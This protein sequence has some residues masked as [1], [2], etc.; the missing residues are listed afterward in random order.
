ME[1]CQATGCENAAEYIDEQ[2]EVYVC[3]NCYQEMIQRT[4]DGMEAFKPMEKNLIIFEENLTADGLAKIQEEAKNLPAEATDKESYKLVYD[5]HQR[6]KRLHVAVRKKADELIAQHKSTFESEKADIEKSLGYVLGIIEPIRDKLG[7]ARKKYDAEEK[8][9]KE[10]AAAEEAKKQQE[11]F[12]RQQKIRDEIDA[13]EENRLFDERR[14]IEEEKAELAEQKR[15]LEETKKL[16]DLAKTHIETNGTP[17]TQEQL[18]IELNRLS[19]DETWKEAHEHD[20]QDLEFETLSKTDIYINIDPGVTNDEL[21]DLPISE[22]LLEDADYEAKKFKNLVRDGE[23]F[24]LKKEDG[25]KEIIDPKRIIAEKKI[26]NDPMD[27]QE[28][29]LFNL[30]HNAEILNY[31]II[32]ELACGFESQEI[33]DY[34]YAF[35][36][37]LI[38]FI[39]QFPK[40]DKEY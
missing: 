15:Q 35:N 36:Q 16:I 20:Q 2:R 37:S 28:M 3:K 39:D 22:D 38:N 25:T 11:E 13:H 29:R 27:R 4:P 9:R 21:S 32:D 5:Q 34:L 8:A 6:F 26:Q 14:Q 1:R 7:T 12:E 10:A 30:K 31:T 24:E 40:F 17:F 33:T 18:D 23:V 19:F